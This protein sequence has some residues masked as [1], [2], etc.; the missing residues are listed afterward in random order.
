MKIQFKAF[1]HIKVR[2]YKAICN[3]IMLLEHW[4]RKL[5]MLM[6]VVLDKVLV[7]HPRLLLHHDCRFDHFSEA[8][9][10]GIASF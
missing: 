4:S 1:S 5:C 2:S 6:I 7:T 3:D 9:G 8:F 10:V